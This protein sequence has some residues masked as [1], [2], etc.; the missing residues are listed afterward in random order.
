MQRQAQAISEPGAAILLGDPPRDNTGGREMTQRPTIPEGWITTPEAAELA[1]C[2]TARIRQ[3][4]ASGQVD[5][6]K[7]GR[8]WLV[9]RESLVAYKA[10]AK[11]GPK[12]PWKHKDGGE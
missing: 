1:N 7:V 2:S 11:R 3:V 8:D 5:C 9:N 12:G 10:T 6:V 4:C